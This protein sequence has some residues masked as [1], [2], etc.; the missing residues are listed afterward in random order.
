MSEQI[1]VTSKP[2]TSEALPPSFRPGS[3]LTSSDNDNSMSD[4]KLKDFQYI[5][6]EKKLS[7]D[8][9]LKTELSKPI[10]S[11]S[12]YFKFFDDASLDFFDNS[13][14]PI[15][16]EDNVFVNNLLISTIEQ[17]IFSLEKSN[18]FA[19]FLLATTRFVD[20]IIFIFLNSKIL[21]ITSLALTAGIIA[22]SFILPGDIGVGISFLLSAP[23]F[24]CLTGII[25][26]Y[27]KYKN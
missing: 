26:K 11:E 12:N 25:A 20:D 9:K 15:I 1:L 27:L 24:V 16:E 5:E 19:N 3:V 14:E 22:S 18:I 8:E 7:S 21:E 17:K 13:D 10:V 6:R 2:L 23:L 4:T